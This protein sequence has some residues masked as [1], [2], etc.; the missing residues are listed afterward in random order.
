LY[1]YEL[2]ARQP[3]SSMYQLFF[4]KIKTTIMTELEIEKLIEEKDRL[5]DDELLKIISNSYDLSQT[6]LLKDPDLANDIEFDVF[7]KDWIKK[8]WK[9]IL[10][11][12]EKLSKKDAVLG[13][14]MTN[15]TLE[16]TK[17]IQSGY[18]FQF[19]ETTVPAIIALVILIKRLATTE[20]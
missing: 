17:L 4:N 18:N 12:T 2:A 14:A 10:L 5:N 11:N 19:S 15:T 1:I 6:I 20:S 3:D 9:K 8:N 7:N 13:W 16:I